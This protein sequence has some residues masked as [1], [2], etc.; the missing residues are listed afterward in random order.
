MTRATFLAGCAALA[1]LVAGAPLPAVAAKATR[2]R[3][4]LP[5]SWPPNWTDESR[6]TPGQRHLHRHGRRT[7]LGR[8][9]PDGAD[10]RFPQARVVGAEGPGITDQLVPRIAEQQNLTS[11]TLKNTLVDDDGIA[12][13]V[14]LKTLR[15]IELRVA[16]V[17][18]DRA[19]ESL[20]KLP[21]LRAV[22]LVGGNITDCG[23]ATLL[24]APGSTN[25]TFAIART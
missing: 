12:Q 1:V 10:S 7:H 3:S 20:V 25:S 8:R 24:R 5:K 13:L 16:P 4:P 19:M 18:T 21:R 23:I 6:R 17:I 14:D 15:V 22:R 2:S 9:L 11:L